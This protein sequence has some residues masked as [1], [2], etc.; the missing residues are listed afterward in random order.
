MFQLVLY[1]QG[2]RRFATIHFATTFVF[3]GLGIGV[4]ALGFGGGGLGFGAGSFGLG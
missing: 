3:W 2:V 1:F 4:W